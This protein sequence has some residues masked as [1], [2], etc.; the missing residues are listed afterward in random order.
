MLLNVGTLLLLDGNSLRSSESASRKRQLYSKMFPD[1]TL[2]E[3]DCG[4]TK[5][6][7]VI[8]F[9]LAPFVKEELIDSFIPGSPFAI[10]VDEST[11]HG[12]VRLE[13]WIIFFKQN[14]RCVRYLTTKEL[15][16]NIDVKSFLEDSDHKGTLKE[17]KLVSS[18][19]VYECTIDVIDEFSLNHSD[20]VHVMTDNCTTMRGVRE[21]FV[22]KIKRDCPNIID[23]DGCSCHRGNL[24]TKDVIKSYAFLKQIVVFVEGLSKFVENKPKV[25]SILQQCS[26]ILQVNQIPD[27]CE[28][29]FLNMYLVIESAC[30]QFPVIKK[31]IAL[32]TE[33]S[34]LK[35]SLQSKH[36]LI[37]LDQFVIHMKPLHD[38]TKRTQSMKGNVNDVLQLLLE[39][40]SKLLVRLGYTVNLSVEGYYNKLY[41]NDKS[42]MFRCKTRDFCFSKDTPCVYQEL[43]KADDN[44]LKT[45]QKNWGGVSE[46][47]LTDILNRFHPFLK[48]ATAR[49][50][51]VLFKD[52]KDF[53]ETS[54]ANMKNLGD[55]AGLSSSHIADD[56]AKLTLTCGNESASLLTLKKN[57]RLSE[58]QALNK[59]VETILVL[60]P[61]NMVVEAGF[62]KMKFFENEHQSQI[63]LEMYNAFRSIADHFDR[64]SF[65]D[66]MPPTSLR[67]RICFASKEYK[68]FCS[69]N[70]SRNIEKAVSAESIRKEVGVFKRK[71]SKDFRREINEVDQ[72]IRDAEIALEA[73]K[74]RKVELTRERESDQERLDKIS[75]AIV[76]QMFE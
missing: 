17:L 74:R 23:I 49:R 45:I 63:S 18:E 21:G 29:R 67:K 12:K 31:L 32:D 2:T 75:E 34:Q 65:E 48:T 26:D 6:G 69:E 61:H 71:T 28:T 37:H 19:A 62:S 35:E 72:E 5:A 58:H 36:L 43:L 4:R 25:R 20:L 47:I 13:Y 9:A 11:Y 52:L 22:A 38:F 8:R 59:L 10:H 51:Y 54:V 1:S 41:E 46:F 40:V 3:I 76:S 70:K 50:S 39:L 60:C 27:Y 56:Y 57:E 7:Y 44:D 66:F 53:T 24:I 73:A 15:H 68:A 14:E 16:T 33:Q 64:D 55:A 42:R 30:R